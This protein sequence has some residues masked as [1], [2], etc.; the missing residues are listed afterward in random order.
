VYRLEQIQPFFGFEVFYFSL[1]NARVK[2]L[3]RV[4]MLFVDAGPPLIYLA[5]V[6]E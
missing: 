4:P 2:N 3:R 5:H 6:L 1:C